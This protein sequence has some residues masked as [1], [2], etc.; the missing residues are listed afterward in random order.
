MSL[1]G[2]GIEDLEG[3]GEVYR[4]DQLVN[5]VVP[6]VVREDDQALLDVLGLKIVNKYLDHE[7]GGLPL[8]YSRC[9]YPYPITMSFF[10]YCKNAKLHFHTNGLCLKKTI[11][12]LKVINANSCF[13]P[14]TKHFYVCRRLYP[15]KRNSYSSSCSIGKKSILFRAIKI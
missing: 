3:L 13:M 11:R 5:L 2:Q 10:I 4:R 6:E 1:D 12:L 15:V 8:S 7:V 9:Q 14:A